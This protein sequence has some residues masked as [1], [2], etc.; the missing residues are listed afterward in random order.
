MPLLTDFG[1]A[2]ALG[3]AVAAPVGPIGLLCIRR[4]MAD[5]PAA[6]FATGLGAATADLLYALCAA[7]GLTAVA[8]QWQWLQPAGALMLLY[9]GIQTWRSA[10][11]AAGG[12]PDEPASLP[13]AFLGTFVLTLLNPMT[14]LSFAAMLA[15]IG[16]T[17]PR[18]LA[19]GVF[20]G[21]AAWW[22]LLSSAASRLRPWLEGPRLVWINRAAAV[23]LA[24]LALQSF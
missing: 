18:L 12:A 17:D 21:S 4:S 2:L 20:L 6:G 8:T 14:I 22:L 11:P 19:P 16:A 13:R 7:A 15:A 5:G 1:K 9:L 10:R 24:A 23:M 3:F